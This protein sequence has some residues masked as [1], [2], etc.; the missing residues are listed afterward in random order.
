MLV[1]GKLEVVVAYLGVVFMVVILENLLRQSYDS[2]MIHSA[3]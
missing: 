1:S 2:H 3:R